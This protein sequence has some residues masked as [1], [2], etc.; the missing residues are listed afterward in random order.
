MASG[1][2]LSYIGNLGVMAGDRAERSRCWE[3]IEWLLKGKKNMTV[4]YVSYKD[5]DDVTVYRVPSGRAI[6][7]IFG[8]GGENLRHIEMT[9][10]VYV[11]N[12]PS[13]D[14]PG[15][16]LLLIYSYSPRAREEALSMMRDVVDERDGRRYDSARPL[17]KN[18][19]RCYDF[20][21]GRCTRGN[22]CKW[23][24]GAEQRGGYDGKGSGGPDRSRARVG[25]PVR[26]G[27]RDPNP[28]A[29]EK[30]SLDARWGSGAHR[31]NT[32]TSM[33]ERLS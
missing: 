22:S 4:E 20:T 18:T 24:H 26:R 28:Y 1:A 7:A 30:K 25:D 5:R 33:A 17:P 10:G 2:S 14:E 13:S 19:S 29:K 23:A 32:G 8:K 3:Y 16:E 15:M 9:C 12:I 6:A 21:V 11:V 31:T 27:G